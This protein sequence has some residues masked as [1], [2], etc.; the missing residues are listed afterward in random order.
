[1]QNKFSEMD[2][3]EIITR[4]RPIVSKTQQNRFK[5]SK[6]AVIGC[7]GIGGT[8]IEMIA[9]MGVGEI[10]IVDS[11][12][13]DMSNLN[14]QVM[15]SLDT[16]NKAK[17]EVTKEKINSIAPFTK[18]NSFNE[19]LTEKNVEKIISNC[20]IIIDGLDNIITRII[21]A[22][23]ANENKI[24]FIH[25]AI[26]G[27]MGQIT[28]FTEETVEYE[29]MFQLNSFKKELNDDII[30]NIKK[31]TADKPPVIGPVP[32]IIGALQAMES[33]KLVTELGTTILAPKILKFDLLNLELF[34]I[35]K[36]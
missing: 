34:K 10:N 4:Q 17:S 22:R 15:S 26:H 2:Y 21:V 31:I 5:N 20:D 27:T 8:A 18:V 24:P 12:I 23:F 7:G 36:L 13:F 9:R 11:D 19:E 30:E 32:N 33:F 35:D 29:E 16:L 3:W 25:G 6:I 28:V 1:M 14:R